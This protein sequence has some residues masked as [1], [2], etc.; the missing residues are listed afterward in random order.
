M[1]QIRAVRQRFA[2]MGQEVPQLDQQVP[3]ALRA[4][5]K[6]EIDKWHPII[7]AA[8]ISRTR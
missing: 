6:S 5:H 4:F 8:N 1:R 2:N 7:K 3:E